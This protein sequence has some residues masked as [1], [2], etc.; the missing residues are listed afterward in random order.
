MA[1]YHYEIIVN[2]SKLGM[3]G[4]VES[5]FGETDSVS[6][7]LNTNNRLVKEELLTVASQKG[8][9]LNLEI[10]KITRYQM[11][12]SDDNSLIEMD[13]TAPF[14]QEDRP[15]NTTDEVWFTCR[16]TALMI[17]PN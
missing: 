1:K 6:L 14:Y 8:S 15:I 13:M 9:L 16:A 7:S 5:F 11:Q 12:I 17:S 3:P 2:L 4:L 10:T